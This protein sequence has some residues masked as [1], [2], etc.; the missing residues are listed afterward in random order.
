[1]PVPALKP[2]SVDA[3]QA[4]ERAE[5]ELRKALEGGRRGSAA[6]DRT[7]GKVVWQEKDYAH[8]STHTDDLAKAGDGNLSVVL[9]RGKETGGA[10]Q[11]D[12]EVL[13]KNDAIAEVRVVTDQGTHIITKTADHLTLPEAFRKTDMT[14]RWVAAND[15]VIKTFGKGLD[16]LTRRQRINEILSRDL[17][18]EARFVPKAGA[19]K[20]LPPPPITPPPTATEI[21]LGDYS[22]KGAAYRKLAA[23]KAEYPDA[24]IVFNEVTKRW[25]VKA[26]A[27]GIVPK[28]TPPPPTPKPPV[29]PPPTTPSLVPYPSGGGWRMPEVTHGFTA[30]FDSRIAARHFA[31]AYDGVV[32]TPVRDA[33]LAI[34]HYEV[35]VAKGTA[36]KVAYNPIPAPRN[37][38]FDAVTPA[39][40]PGIVIPAGEAPSEAIA[41]AMM[42]EVDRSKEAVARLAREIKEWDDE[43][44]KQY[45]KMRSAVNEADRRAGEDAYKVATRKKKALSAERTEMER[46]ATERIR[47]T[48]Y[49]AESSTLRI[50]DHLSATAGH[51][52]A[53]RFKEA[54]EAF[55]KMVG[56]ETQLEGR[57]LR[58]EFSS[59][60]AFYRDSGEMTSL[61]MRYAHQAVHEMGHWLENRDGFIKREAQA[62]LRR[63]TAGE[64]ASPLRKLVGSWYDAD[65]MAK[66]D[67]FIDAYMGKVYASGD[68]EIVSMAM[69]KLYDD[70]LEFMRRDREM[71]DWIVNILHRYP[72]E[73]SGKSAVT[74]VARTGGSVFRRKAT[75]AIGEAMRTAADDAARTAGSYSGRG[76]AYRKLAIERKAGSEGKVVLNP[77]TGRFEVIVTRESEVAKIIKPDVT[78]PVPAKR[79]VGTYRYRADAEE[80]MIRWM[81]AVPEKKYAVERVIGAGEKE[82]HVIETV[83]EARPVPPRPLPKLPDDVFPETGVEI[84]RFADMEKAVLEAERL[85]KTLPAKEYITLDFD[86][87]TSEIR[88]MSYARKPA[89]GIDMGAYDS[90]EAAEAM[91]GAMRKAAPEPAKVYVVEM[92]ERPGR[93]TEWKI[94]AYPDEAAVKPIIG[95]ILPPEIITPPTPLPTTTVRWTGTEFDFRADAMDKIRGT[96]RQ[97]AG[98]DL[99]R[100]A[101]RRGAVSLA[102]H[103]GRGS[104]VGGAAHRASGRGAASAG[105]GAAGRASGDA[106]A[107]GLGLHGRGRVLRARGRGTQAED[108][109]RDHQ[110]E[111]EGGLEPGDW[112]VGSARAGGD[113]RDASA[114]SA[115]GDASG[116][117]E[118]DRAEAGPAAGRD[119]RAHGLGR[120]PPPEEDRRAER[121]EQGRAV[122][123]AE[124]REVVRQVLRGRG[125][126]ARRASRER[127]L[128]GPGRSG[129]RV[130]G[131]HLQ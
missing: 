130:G 54:V 11:G 69:Q 36:G 45:G 23:V 70:P 32:V 116:A 27:K 67:K 2:I 73:T 25:E 3:V 64:S 19:V 18:V 125:A 102:A 105:G 1:M 15:E 9:T 84:G 113:R 66:P 61:N 111:G 29:P 81:D 75:E 26:T 77:A 21:V 58:A 107:A 4:A 40:T 53:E 87:A 20:P 106:S 115:A 55:R 65:E 91:A 59:R 89:G 109:P 24:K 47:A 60:R 94:V 56:R 50:S 31:E 127:D 35:R 93:R 103:G 122:S 128:P 6:I 110:P 57:T 43:S 10:M 101:V 98:E 71:F 99:H 96:P 49:H 92:V 12:W 108:R 28:P 8:I 86:P 83:P 68:T 88:L 39:P 62:F 33:K 82:W 90:K 118:A 14:T 63:R 16:D 22:G 112:Q 120:Q 42:A 117:A 97:G 7:T 119:A 131:R 104:E 95:K 44:W 38:V 126:G 129:A 114:A 30:E 13:L 46:D 17:K 52:E 79:T 100:R 48:F 80:E 78:P 76:A 5:L 51:R 34:S 41:R 123:V 124:R 72:V 85:R 121:V 74:A 37:V